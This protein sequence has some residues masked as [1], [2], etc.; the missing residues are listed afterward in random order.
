MP[1]SQFRALSP[2]GASGP[3]SSP[4]LAVGH[5]P[6]GSYVVRKGEAPISPRDLGPVSSKWFMLEDS[7]WFFSGL[8]IQ[9]EGASGLI[10]K[11]LDVKLKMRESD[12]LPGVFRKFLAEFCAPLC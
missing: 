8:P 2:T 6:D 5:S 9:Y 12:F 11:V 7:H 3:V 4:A 10:F 1:V